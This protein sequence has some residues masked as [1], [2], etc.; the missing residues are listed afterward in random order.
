MVQFSNTDDAKCS[1]ENASAL[2]FA[3]MRIG[4]WA[5][6]SVHESDSIPRANHGET[7]GCRDSPSLSTRCIEHLSLEACC[8][9]LGST[10][11]EG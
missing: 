8:G 5:A 6:K 7:G 10:R 3:W 2:D 4:R 11:A 9:T 1:N